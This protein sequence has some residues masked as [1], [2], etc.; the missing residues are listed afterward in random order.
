MEASS[1][2]TTWL[3]I[4]C[5]SASTSGGKEPASSNKAGSRLPSSSSRRV[6]AHSHARRERGRLHHGFGPMSA[7]DAMWP[8]V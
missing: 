3:V 1:L 6:L 8:I 7:D 2:S 5:D 4:E